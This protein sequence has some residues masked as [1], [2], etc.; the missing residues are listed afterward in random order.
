MLAG[1]NDKKSI[2]NESIKDLYNRY[3]RDLE[4]KFPYKVFFTNWKQDSSNIRFHV[5]L[6]KFMQEVNKTPFDVRAFAQEI[7]LTI[8]EER[9]DIDISGKLENN[10]I[11][12]N[13]DNYFSILSQENLLE[14]NID[15]NQSYFQ[16]KEIT[17]IIY[18]MIHNN[19]KENIIKNKKLNNKY[20][21]NNN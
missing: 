6:E 21:K 5:I 16:T 14:S 11:T 18:N 12:L 15:P 1:I 13:E 19:L 9:L 17:N 10:I 20:N 2:R 4:S 7:N 3:L 8:N